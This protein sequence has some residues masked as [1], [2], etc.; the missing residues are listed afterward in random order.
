MIFNTI[1]KLNTQS[2]HLS[3][4][5][6]FFKITSKCA[7]LMTV[8]PEGRQTLQPDE[9]PRANQLLLFIYFPPLFVRHIEIVTAIKER[10][11]AGGI[12]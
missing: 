9:P 6:L 4:T 12:F 1:C 7:Q 5:S 10:R 3:K 2:R 11:R 8:H